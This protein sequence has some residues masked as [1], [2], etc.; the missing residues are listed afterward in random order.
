VFEG[1]LVV[2][3]DAGRPLFDNLLF[4]R[5]RPTYVAFDLLM[6]ALIC[7]RYRSG[8]VKRGWRGSAKGPRAGL[9]SP[10]A[11][12]VTGGRSSRGGRGRS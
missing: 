10:T 9:R 2:L 7:D 11:L 8:T 12:S 5:G 4:G 1:E 6:E 3:D